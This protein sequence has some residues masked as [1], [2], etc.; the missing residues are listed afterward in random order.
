MTWRRAWNG[1]RGAIRVTRGC[2]TSGWPFTTRPS[3]STSESRTIELWSWDLTGEG[4]RA[5]ENRCGAW[6][7]SIER[8]VSSPRGVRVRPARLESLASSFDRERYLAAVSRVLEFIAAGDV[9]QVNV[10]QRYLAT[11]RPEPLDLY[12]RLKAASPAPFAAFLHWD[13]LAVV[14]ASP[15]LF[16]ETRGETLVTRPIKGTRPRGARPRKTSGSPTSYGIRPRTRPS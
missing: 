11:G 3:S 6:R 12:L 16:F 9:F 15:E 13:D 7:E 8:S 4:R 14:S 1:C 10:S 5:A 2:P